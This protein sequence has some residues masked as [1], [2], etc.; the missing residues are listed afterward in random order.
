[1]LQNFEI[2]YSYI[3]NVM[4]LLISDIVPEDVQL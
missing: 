1:M 2:F 3:R 4:F